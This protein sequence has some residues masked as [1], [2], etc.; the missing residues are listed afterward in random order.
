MDTAEGSAGRC[1]VSIC[2]PREARKISQFF[3]A[4]IWMSSRSTF[5]LCFLLPCTTGLAIPAMNPHA[6]NYNAQLK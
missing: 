6:H 2:T 4:V 5:V 1:V 3:S